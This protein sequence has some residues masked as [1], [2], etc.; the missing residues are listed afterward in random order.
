MTRYKPAIITA[1]LEGVFIPEIWVAV[2][3][4]MGVD[5]LR[6]TTRDI[7]DYDQLM[8]YRLQILKE[9][10]ITLNDIQKVISQIDPLPGAAEFLAWIRKRTQIIIITD[11]YYQFVEPILPKLSNPTVFAHNLVV[12]DHNQITDY[13]LRTKDG[14]RKAVESFQ[15]MGFRVMAIGDSYNDTAM[16]LRADCSFLFCPPANVV[17]DYPALSVSSDYAKLTTEIEQF[18]SQC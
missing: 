14:K 12:N 6:L 4:Q 1:D 2:A 13:H 15:Q 5:E 18:L 7:S 10:R 9:H 16:L 17:Q 11:S 8:T 3:V